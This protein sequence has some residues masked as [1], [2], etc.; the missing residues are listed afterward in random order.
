MVIVNVLSKYTL[1]GQSICCA[2]ISK[3]PLSYVL[4]RKC[5]QFNLLTI[6]DGAGTRERRKTP[7]G[8]R[9]VSARDEKAGQCSWDYYKDRLKN[10]CLACSNLLS[11]MENICKKEHSCVSCKVLGNRFL[12]LYNIMYYRNTRVELNRSLFNSSLDSL[13]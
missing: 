5:W 10:L 7:N 4:I 3:L 1:L 11:E 9:Q 13:D 12:T 6:L 2:S 8:P